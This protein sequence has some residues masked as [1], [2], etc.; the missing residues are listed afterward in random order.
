MRRHNPFVV[1]GLVLLFTACQTAPTAPSKPLAQ[2][3]PAPSPAQERLQSHWIGIA[4]VVSTADSGSSCGWGISVGDTRQN[5]EWRITITGDSIALAV[6]M[7]NWPTDHTPYSGS[8]SGRQFT[9]SYDQGAD[10]AKY[11][12][13]FKVGTLSGRFSA[14]FSSFEA[15]ETL[16]WG[17]PG[18]ERTAQRQW[19]GSRF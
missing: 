4:T 6:D 18:A 13:Q 16:V 5:V 3:S 8:L 15:V 11:I 17:V 1:L 19:A 2:A 14:D 7:R 12:C 10:Y 9:A